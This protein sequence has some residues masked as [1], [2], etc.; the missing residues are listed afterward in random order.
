MFY[1]MRFRFF[2]P[3]ASVLHDQVRKRMHRGVEADR[4]AERLRRRSRL[5]V[6]EI[7]R[8]WCEKYGVS[9]QIAAGDVAD[10]HE[11]VK[12]LL[13]WRNPQA[14]WRTLALFS[15]ATAFVTFVPAHI[16]WKTTFF[17]LGLIFFALLV[18]PL[19]FLFLALLA[20]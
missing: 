11:K 18:S 2:P 6:L 7:Y 20:F 14:T 13:L 1:I 3:D 16:V 19:F 5:D 8:R 10:F 15:I 9:T 12:N 17:F 4:L